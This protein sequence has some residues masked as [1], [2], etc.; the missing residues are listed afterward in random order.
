MLHSSIFLQWWEEESLILTGSRPTATLVTLV[1]F[2]YYNKLWAVVDLMI[3]SDSSLR[4]STVASETWTVN[5]A[6]E[7]NTTHSSHE[8]RGGQN[9]P[10]TKAAVLTSM[11]KHQVWGE[12][13]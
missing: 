1:L 7:H 5:E 9:T 13:T 6:G 10:E 12:Q 2:T 4:Q 3:G 11:T 8:H